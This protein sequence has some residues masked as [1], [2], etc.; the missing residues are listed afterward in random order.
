MTTNMILK[1]LVWLN[2]AHKEG[3]M[4]H[5][6][7]CEVSAMEMDMIHDEIDTH[8]VDESFSSTGPLNYHRDP[9]PSVTLCHSEHPCQPSLL[10]TGMLVCPPETT[11]F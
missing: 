4:R 10:L 7:L 8:L 1:K 9:S 5:V 2:K 3:E 6:Y 11:V